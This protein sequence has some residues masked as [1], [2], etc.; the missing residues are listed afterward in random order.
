MRDLLFS[1][2]AALYID[3]SFRGCY[4]RT[5]HCIYA[6][7]DSGMRHRKALTS[8][9]RRAVTTL[10]HP[11][12]SFHNQ[13]PIISG[14]PGVLLI[15]D[16]RYFAYGFISGVKRGRYSRFFILLASTTSF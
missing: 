11:W 14:L 5:V 10:W 16:W 7:F 2:F 12:A 15:E 1:C 6:E 13:P 3:I 9:N 4:N 8:L